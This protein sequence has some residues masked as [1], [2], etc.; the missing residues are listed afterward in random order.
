MRCSI[1]GIPIRDSSEGIWD[2]GE[3]ISREWM[4]NP[5]LDGVDTPG[6]FGPSRAWVS[7]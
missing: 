5:G 6:S 2:D 7:W 1:A 3:W 4:D